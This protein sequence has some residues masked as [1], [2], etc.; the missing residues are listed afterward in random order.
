MNW[1]QNIYQKIHQRIT[2]HRKL[3]EIRKQDP[4]IYK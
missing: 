3:K 1:I 2:Y 4:Y